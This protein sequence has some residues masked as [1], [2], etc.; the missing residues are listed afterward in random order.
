MDST[1]SRRALLKAAP[2]VAA[3][4]ALPLPAFAGTSRE[5]E[6]LKRNYADACRRWDVASEAE[7]RRDSEEIDFDRTAPFRRVT[8]DL[9]GWEH[10]GK[11]ITVVAAP[12]EET[13]TLTRGNVDTVSDEFKTLPE[14]AAF[15][16]E[17]AAWEEARAHEA[18]ARGWKAAAEEWYEALNVQDEAWRA[19]VAFPVTNMAMLAEKIELATQHDMMSNSELAEDLISA[20]ASDVARLNVSA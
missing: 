5:W 8:C 12:T 13:V 9:A 14:Y 16:E 1:T 2:V 19:L 15:R 10:Q 20:M 3:A 7:S 6:R 17:L 4:I 18:A 11:N